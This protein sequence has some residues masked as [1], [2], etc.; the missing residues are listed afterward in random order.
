MFFLLY[1][2]IQILAAIVLLPKLIRKLLFDK[3]RSLVE[4]FGFSL[5]KAR[6]GSGP[7]FMLY[8]VSVGEV[9]AISFLFKEMK[10]SYPTASFYIAC[11]TKT[12]FEEAKRSLV[13]AD[14]YFLLPFDFSW[15]CKKLIKR[16]RPSVLLVVEGDLWYNLLKTARKKGSL[17]CLISAKISLRSYKRFSLVPFFAKKLFGCFTLICAQNAVFAKRFVDLGVS[18]SSVIVTGNIKLGSHKELLQNLEVL[19]LRR[20]FG[21]NEKDFVIVI[22]STHAPEE[23]EIVEKL[24]PLWDLFPH[25]K[26]LLV[27]RH[28]E[29][30]AEV[31]RVLFFEDIPFVSFSA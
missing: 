5:P 20:K 19:S 10:K 4:Y 23:V 8:A 25:M 28:P 14:S 16:L 1:D 12:G 6:T 30:F 31:R 26:C 17:V 27:P 9:K 24:K 3:D 11:R 7:C 15:V 2:F 21:I 29:R 18:P 22:G 13:G